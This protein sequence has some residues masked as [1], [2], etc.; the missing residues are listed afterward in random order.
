MT[1]SGASPMRARPAGGTVDRMSVADSYVAALDAALVGPGR[2]R[3]GLVQEARDHLEDAT[4]AYVRAGYAEVESQRRA[5]E[6]FG[7]LEEVVPAFQSTLAVASSRRTA[8]LLLGVLSIQP[9]LWDGGHQAAENHAP[10]GL[11]YA[12]LD[13]GIEVVGGLF[14]VG[15]ALLLLA[16]GIGHRW[17]DVGRPVA[18]AT[19]A[20]ALLAASM[21][22][23]IG[24][25][26]TLLSG[27]VAASHWAMLLV[28]LWAPMSL[29]AVS[30]R[31]TL[32]TC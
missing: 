25:T 27:G 13:V 17:F 16:T 12:V 3:R 26:M 24:V 7:R 30:A 20:L 2:V 1:G 4:D 11:A 9:F 19:S 23:A 28:F 21:T 29:T 31:R 10:D 8:A 32:A 18:R 22:T 6:D 15:A 14:I 5:V